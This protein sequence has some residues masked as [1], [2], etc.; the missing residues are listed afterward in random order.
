MIRDAMRHACAFSGVMLL[1]VLQPAPALAQYSYFTSSSFYFNQN[2]YPD[3][4]GATFRARGDDSRTGSRAR[5]GTRSAPTTTGSTAVSATN[6]PLPYTRS[7]AVSA[8]VKEKNLSNMGVRGSAREVA[9]LRAMITENDL[10]Q[11]FADLA[12][13]EGLDGG[14]PE[15]ITALWYGQT[16]AM[17][18]RQPL[19]TSRQY[20]GLQRQLRETRAYMTAW[21]GRDNDGRQEFVEM[22]VYPLIMQRS[23]YRIYLRE[24]NTAAIA[25]VSERL[26][27]L[28]L[29]FK[30]DMRSLQ[31]GD[32]GFVAR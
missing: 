11:I 5:T 1:A 26:Q 29:G 21:D 31:L 22:L 15:G 28:M 12:R 27:A 17:A 14:T 8:R 10:V 25:E 3:V 18:S 13:L 6:N 4:T 23:H 9:R 32:S 19:P 30:M 7:S 16:W 20:Q 24:G 2:N